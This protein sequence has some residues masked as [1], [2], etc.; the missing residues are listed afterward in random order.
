MSTAGFKPAISAVKQLQICVLDL[1]ATG[2]E[3]ISYQCITVPLR[4]I[5]LD[6]GRSDLNVGNCFKLSPSATEKDRKGLAVGWMMGLV[7]RPKT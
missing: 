5:E 7:L 6:E 4:L 2:I 1:T 3:T